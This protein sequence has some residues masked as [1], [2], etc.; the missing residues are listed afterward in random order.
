MKKMKNWKLGLIIA[1]VIFLSG[2]ATMQVVPVKGFSFKTPL[3][4]TLVVGDISLKEKVELPQEEINK[5]RET[6]YGAFK[7][8]LP[9]YQILMSSP[10]EGD[11]LTIETKIVYI[12]KSRPL[13]LPMGLVA[14][15]I[16]NG[17]FS[18]FLNRQNQTQVEILKTKIPS[19]RM[20]GL[21][22]GKYGAYYSFL[23]IVAQKIAIEFKKARQ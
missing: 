11:F 9:E 17:E 21:I 12:R 14:T 8:E 15:S 2:C 16:C 20:A 10:S 1:G 19:M 6:L 23:K 13:L 5:G 3:P 22:Y 7:E 4:K 18:V